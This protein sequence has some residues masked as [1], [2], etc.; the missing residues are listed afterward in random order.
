MEAKTNLAIGEQVVESLTGKI[1]AMK[2]A[3]IHT[4][5]QEIVTETTGK[6]TQ[7]GKYLVSGEHAGGSHTLKDSQLAELQAS[8]ASEIDDLRRLIDHFESKSQEL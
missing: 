3:G 2:R 6:A 8:H 5:V 7:G 4:A 1:A